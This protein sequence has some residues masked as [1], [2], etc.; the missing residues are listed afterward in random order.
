MRAADPEIL[1]KQTCGIS[2]GAN[3]T[4]VAEFAKEAAATEP[5]LRQRH[6]QHD[7]YSVA[8]T[9][10]LTAGNDRLLREVVKEDVRKELRQLGFAIAPA[11]PASSLSLVAEVV[12]EEVQRGFALAEGG[13]VP[14]RLTYAEAV[15]RPIDATSAELTT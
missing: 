10:A 14:R 1:R 12:R 4:T 11:E 3:P 7:S 6:R 8:S 15:S 9:C 13:N 2:Y 5:A